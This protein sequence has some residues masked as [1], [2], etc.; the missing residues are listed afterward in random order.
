MIAQIK[1][2]YSYKMLHPQFNSQ[3]HEK[4]NER[5]YPKTRVWISESS[6]IIAKLTRGNF[7]LQPPSPFH[8]K[9][10]SFLSEIHLLCNELQE[11][12]L[13]PST[14][15][16][17][18]L[19]NRTQNLSIIIPQHLVAIIRCCLFA[20]RSFPLKICRNPDD[21]QQLPSKKKMTTARKLAMFSLLF[22][23]SLPVE[24]VAKLM[25]L[26]KS[27]SLC[28]EKVKY[29][30]FLGG[31]KHDELEEAQPFQLGCWIIQLL[32]SETKLFIGRKLNK[33]AKLDSTFSGNCI[34]IAWKSAHS[35]ENY[36]KHQ[37]NV[38]QS[39]KLP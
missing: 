20:A 13:I 14:I 25:Q 1:R 19:F 10:Q 31:S 37:A 17:G 8:V 7:L 5:N 34:L 15:A 30:S 16:V 29:D 28:G 24:S 3:N 18:S 9:I 36:S 26:I 21:S 33:K 6:T 23:N 32:R 27:K 12:W 35:L 11:A 39:I 22:Q 38:T 4:P 2:H